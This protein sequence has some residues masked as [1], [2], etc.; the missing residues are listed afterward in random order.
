MSSRQKYAILWESMVF[1]NSTN[2]L[3]AIHKPILLPLS[4]DGKN[5]IDKYKHFNNTFCYS[6]DKFQ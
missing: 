3:Y 2:P 1:N 4:Y 5:D 6:N